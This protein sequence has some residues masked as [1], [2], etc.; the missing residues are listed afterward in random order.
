MLAKVMDIVVV[1]IEGVL[2]LL[3][4]KEG[5]VTQIEGVDYKEEALFVKEVV[6][7]SLF[8]DFEQNKQKKTTRSLNR[9]N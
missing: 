5:L 6:L 7:A 3:V 2:E 4:I 8:L 9:K 1:Q